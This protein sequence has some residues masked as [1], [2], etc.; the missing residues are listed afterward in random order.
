[1]LSHG[2]RPTNLGHE[3]QLAAPAPEYSPGKQSLQA[4]CP[5]TMCVCVCVCVFVCV[6]V[7]TERERD[8]ERDEYSR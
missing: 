2:A 1:M 4:E 3:E 5:E 7:C 8:R 6:G